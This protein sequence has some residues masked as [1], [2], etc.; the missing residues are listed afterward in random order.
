MDS[1][2]IRRRLTLGPALLAAAGLLAFAASGT[3]QAAPS[4]CSGDQVRTLS[5]GSGVTRVYRQG[6]Y[7]CAMTLARSPGTV[8]AMSVSVQA[9][10]SRPARDAGH[11]LSHA[12]PVTVHAGHRCVWIRGTVGQ[13]SVSSGWI[14]C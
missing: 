14:L 3:A 11:F 8:R 7:V 5:F 9:R 13:N 2:A 12:G 4:S 1:G 6:D 10:G